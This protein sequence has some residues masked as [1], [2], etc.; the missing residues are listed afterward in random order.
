VDIAVGAA[1]LASDLDQSEADLAILAVNQLRDR[2]LRA[3]A[4]QQ[5]SAITLAATLRQLR[6]AEL[7]IVRLKDQ[8]SKFGG[9]PE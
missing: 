8:L 5:A 2:Y 7:E 1:L 4:G 9:K 3:A 6:A